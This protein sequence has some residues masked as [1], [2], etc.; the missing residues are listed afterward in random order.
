MTGEI[1]GDEGPWGR[2]ATA[3]TVEVAV[4]LEDQVRFNDLLFAAAPELRRA[5]LRRMALL[6]LGVPI[7]GLAIAA[8]AI[9]V[10]G[11]DPR[12]LAARIAGQPGMLGQAAAAAAVALV[13]G[14]ALF[15]IVARLRMK[16]AIREQLRE[17]S[18]V[19]AADPS[20]MERAC[21]TF[22]PDGF[23][24]VTA[25]AQVHVPSHGVRALLTEPTLMVVRTGRMAGFLLP[26]RDL[27]ADEREAV[28]QVCVRHGVPIVEAEF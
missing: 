5:T 4:T 16:R 6:I 10:A 18:G 24:S 9:I 27:T 19:D 2:A 23:S 12:A 26:T 14:T 20:L 7:V 11:G 8:A 15:L 13:V 17:R 21:C 22:G 28:R 25:T 3:V 1:T